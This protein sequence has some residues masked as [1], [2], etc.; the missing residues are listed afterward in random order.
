VS[1]FRRTRPIDARARKRSTQW[2]IA[3][4][5]NVV[6]IVVLI[7]VALVAVLS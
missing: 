4:H 3:K 1:T 2:F 7:L 6:A 5:R